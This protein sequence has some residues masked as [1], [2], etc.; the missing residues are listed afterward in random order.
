VIVGLDSSLAPSTVDALL[1]ACGTDLALLGRMRR[2]ARA[3][4]AGVSPAKHVIEEKG[5]Q[6]LNQLSGF[7]TPAS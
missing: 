5:C 3:L 1:H 6:Q 4:D 2:F 7:I